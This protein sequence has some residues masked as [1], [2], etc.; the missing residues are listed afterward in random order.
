MWRPPDCWSVAWLCRLELI[1]RD[2]T[3]KG[4][5]RKHSI[6]LGS[7]NMLNH[8]IGMILFRCVNR[9]IIVLKPATQR[10]VVAAE[11]KL[12][13]QKQTNKYILSIY[14]HTFLCIPPYIIAKTDSPFYYK[15]LICSTSVSNL[16][17]VL[18]IFA[19][20]CP[21][22]VYSSFFKF[23]LMFN[24]NYPFVYIKYFFL[25][26]IWKLWPSPVSCSFHFILSSSSSCIS[27]IF[28]YKWW[29]NK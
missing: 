3:E 12:D 24:S 22:C 19:I 25:L 7:Y 9:A 8:N 17:K 5:Y 1:T 6:S 28:L 2:H 18:Y 27:S 21:S 14:P 11:C 23:Q 20:T 10:S 13:K 16:N 26:C 15:S 4:L 29:I